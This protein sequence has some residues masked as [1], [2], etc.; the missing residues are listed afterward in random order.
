MESHGSQYTPSNMESTHNDNAEKTEEIKDTNQY[1]TKKILIPAMA[2]IYLS[3]FLVALVRCIT[4]TNPAP[5][6]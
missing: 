1:P 2:A 6:H 5:H 4:P 3:V